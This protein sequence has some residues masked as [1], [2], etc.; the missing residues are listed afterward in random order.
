M[1]AIRLRVRPCSARCSP[2][3]VGRLTRSSPSSCLTSIARALASESS[4]LGPF[5]LTC[6]GWMLTSTPSGTAIGCLPI[7]LIALPDPRDELAADPG[8]ASV[9]AAHDSTRGGDDR[10][11]H[12]A[13]HLGDL[14]RAHVAPVARAREAVEARD[15]RPAVLG[16]LQRHAQG[17]AH[18]SGLDL[19]VLDVP[20]LAEDACDV[21]LEG[22]GG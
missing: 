9:V 20:L 19:E 11:A 14:A 13:Q 17:L 1:F 5:T 4:P 18:A 3:S 21:G 15:H 12:A 7:R 16:V 22:R 6:S 10:G 2:R 8:A